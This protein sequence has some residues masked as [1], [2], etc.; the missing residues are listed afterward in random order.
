MVIM[1]IVI[2]VVCQKR[3]AIYLIEMGRNLFASLEL[4]I[5]KGKLLKVR[6]FFYIYSLFFYI[7]F[8]LY[9]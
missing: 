4:V 1:V 5:T 7:H 9:I 6:L 3:T 8:Y 2:F